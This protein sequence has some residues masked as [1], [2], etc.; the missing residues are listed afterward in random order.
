MRNK[1]QGSE[2]EGRRIRYLWRGSFCYL[3]RDKDC[4]VVGLLSHS[5]TGLI[6]GSK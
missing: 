1:G 3:Q 2:A 6:S 4:K 5:G